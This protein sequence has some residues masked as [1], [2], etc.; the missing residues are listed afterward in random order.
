MSCIFCQII[1][2]ELPCYKVYEDANYLAFLDIYPMCEGHTLVIPKQ[3]FPH[4]WDVVQVGEYFEVARK[5]ALHIKK[6]MGV[7]YVDSTILG[8]GV[9]HAHIHLKPLNGEWKRIC[10]ERM[11]VNMA[12]GNKIKSELAVKLGEMLKL[13]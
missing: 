12:E 10:T 5:L 7:D 11:E 4:V 1:A 3:H 6:A 13:C 2:G 9:P 8:R